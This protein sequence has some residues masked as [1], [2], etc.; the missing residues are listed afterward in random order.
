MSLLLLFAGL[1]KVSSIPVS[2][3]MGIE[4][5]IEYE[6]ETEIHINV[7][8]KVEIELIQEK[9]I[10]AKPKEEKIILK[11]NTNILLLLDE[12]FWLLK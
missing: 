10:I 5:F 4:P 6:Y 2:K 11:Q 7:K 3:F 9:I 12:D 1:G 8:L